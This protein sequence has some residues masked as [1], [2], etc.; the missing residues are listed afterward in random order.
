MNEGLV[1]FV[2]IGTAVIV[3]IR[4]VNALNRASGSSWT[5]PHGDSPD[6][7]DAEGAP[8]KPKKKKKRK[9]KPDAAPGEGDNV[10]AA[11]M[12]GASQPRARHYAFA[13]QFLRSVT[14]TNPA[15]W[16]GVRAAAASGAIDKILERMWDEV[17]EAP[18]Q[19]SGH[20]PTGDALEDGVL[21]RMSDPDGMTECYSIA[22]LEGDDGPRYFTLE[23]SLMNAVL[24]E[25]TDAAH[26]NFGPC[27][28]DD[29][30][31]VAAARS[32]VA[33]AN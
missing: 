20:A 12:E 3:V 18:G 4:L 10:L 30:T 11:A 17:D 5:R 13:H 2:A 14:V 1:I 33:P 23:K 28:I 9:K 19:D 25:W 16:K 22:I 32:K 15:V 8:T 24:C 7:A 29:A 21:I 26:V 6:G 31:F 27:A